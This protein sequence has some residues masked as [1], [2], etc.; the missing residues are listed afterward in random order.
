MEFIENSLKQ[1]LFNFLVFKNS[2]FLK[3]YLEIYV[4]QMIK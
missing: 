3:F 1:H 2:T 4:S